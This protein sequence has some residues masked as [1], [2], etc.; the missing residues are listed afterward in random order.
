MA[1]EQPIQLAEISKIALQLSRDR[2]RPIHQFR[3]RRIELPLTHMVRGRCY[4]SASKGSKLSATAE[5]LPI[6]SCAVS[7]SLAMRPSNSGRKV[8][9][10]P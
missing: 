3:L 6:G 2:L 4:R 8:V 9:L 10:V 1:A 7:I 5:L